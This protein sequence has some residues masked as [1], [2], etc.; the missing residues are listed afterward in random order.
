MNIRCPYGETAFDHVQGHPTDANKGTAS[1]LK[2][3]TAMNAV[4]AAQ[5]FKSMTAKKE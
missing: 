1:Y 2:M 4:L 5:K 3:K